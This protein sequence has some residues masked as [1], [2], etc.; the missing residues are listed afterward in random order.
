MDN[1]TFHKSHKT[2]ELIAK[3]GCV[4]LYLLPYSQDLNPIEKFLSWL[5]TKHREIAG[6]LKTFQGAI[7]YNLFN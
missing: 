2:R 5:K 3:T 1:V 7:H 6:N 4:L